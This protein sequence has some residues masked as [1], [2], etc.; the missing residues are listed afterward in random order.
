MYRK[1]FD[2]NKSY[3]LGEMKQKGVLSIDTAVGL[4]RPLQ[5]V[6]MYVNSVKNIQL[7]NG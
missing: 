3:H 6:R 5:Y 1:T 4:C 7:L 2:F